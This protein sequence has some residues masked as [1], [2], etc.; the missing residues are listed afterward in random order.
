M[1]LERACWSSTLKTMI[2][3]TDLVTIRAAE[4][5]D[6]EWVVD[7]MHTALEPYYGGDH[8]A[9]ARRIFEAHI[10]GGID[11][12]G[13]FSFEQRMFIAEI[14]GLRAG[15]I[16]IVGK[17]QATYKISPLIVSPEFQGRCGAGSKLLKH[18]EYY[19]RGNA[20]RQLYCTVAEKNVSAMAFFLHKGFIR[21]GSSDSHYKNGVTETMLYK[22]LYETATVAAFDQHHI[23]VVPLDESRDDHMKQVRD[24]LIEKLS[25]SFE[26]IDDTW[27]SALFSGYSRRHTADINSKYKVIFVALDSNGQ[28]IGVAAGTPKKGSPIKIMPFIAKHLVAFEALLVD[29]PYQMVSYGHKLYVHIDPMPDEVIAL[30]RLGWKLNAAMPSAYAENVITQQWSLDIGEK[31]M[32]TIRVKQRFFD[33]IRSGQ[34]T[35][36]VRIGYENIKRI[37]PG[38]H[39]QLVTFQSTL[40]VRVKTVRHY[41][42]FRDML[43]AEPYQKIAPDSPSEED[44]LALLE[45]I[46]PPHKQALGVIVLELDQMH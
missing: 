40:E 25:K 42:T 27:V 37:R 36:E 9:H 28:V 26:G 6:F 15:L 1:P 22:P 29:L 11:R 3:S 31:T 18:A 35:L 16:H 2:A 4:R 21:A 41:R 43:S 39:I 10:G 45:T 23:S 32:R 14:N 5:D 20:A 30:Q 24:M 12:I 44:V 17:R 8:R 7:L 46:Y 38:E 33:L 34:K 19:A 13:F